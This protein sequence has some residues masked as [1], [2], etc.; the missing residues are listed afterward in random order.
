MIVT[1]TLIASV[2][3]LFI[4]TLDHVNTK[5]SNVRFLNQLNVVRVINL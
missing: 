1:A 2:L 5:G 4:V 3:F